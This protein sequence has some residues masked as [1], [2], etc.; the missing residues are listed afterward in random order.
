MRIGS[1]T[2][3]VGHPAFVVAEIGVNHDGQV[4]RALE[5]VDAAKAAGADAIKLQ[6]F[7][8]ATLVH[9][10]GL[11]ADYQ[12]QTT[13]AETSTDL[14]RKLELSEQ[15]LQRVHA[16]AKARGLLSIATPFSPADVPV[17]QRLGLDAIKIASPDLVNV[18]LLEAVMKT[19]LPLL[20]STGAATLEEID[21]T[22]LLLDGRP[23]SYL[24]CVSSYPTPDDQAH[25]TFIPQLIARYPGIPI[26]Y[27]DHAH[28]LL[29]GGLAV[30][31]GALVLERH[32]T[33]DK[34]AHG[35]DHSASSD[36]ADFA[37]YVKVAR[38]AATLLGSGSKR[39][40]PIEQDV[41]KVSRQSLVLTVDLPAG[42]PL[43]SEHLV[44]QRP[45]TGIPAA[46][47]YEVIGRT[48]KSPQKA[49][50]MLSW[51]LLT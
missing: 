45:G 6:V 15:D 3:A 11:L 29:S 19:R 13:T 30:A 40:L 48:L 18:P 41:R 24:H 51:D 46:A 22:H 35:P 21:A 8:A 9:G 23:R 7:R 28:S 38:V 25:L 50:T 4:K 36:P 17:C 14:L 42:S 33:Y 1:H 5:L 47:F 27:S 16:Y 44:P 43:K 31:A 2:V 34:A 20:L 37:E 12:K 49:H 10:T 32:L 26:G 39:V